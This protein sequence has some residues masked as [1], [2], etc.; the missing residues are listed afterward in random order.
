MDK[1]TVRNSSTDFLIFAQENGGDGIEVRVEDETIW[2]TQKL[3]ADLFETSTQ[4]IQQ[5]LVNI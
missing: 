5:H 1:T 3:M 4:N 2:L